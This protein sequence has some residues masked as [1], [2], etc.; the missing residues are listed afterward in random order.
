MKL[1]GFRDSESLPFYYNMQHSY[2]IY[3]DE[4]VDLL[5][6]NLQTRPGST[7]L[8]KG[9]LIKMHEKKKLA[10]CSFSPQKNSNPQ[11]A[12]ILPQV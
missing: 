4:K 2:F 9:L 3:P 10:I 7:T 6:A 11:L 8:F 5:I 12:V 1:L